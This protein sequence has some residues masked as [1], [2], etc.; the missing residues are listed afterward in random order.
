MAFLVVC[1]LF[2]LIPIICC[3]CCIPG[4]ILH[5][6]RER[7]VVYQVIQWQ[8]LIVSGS[9]RNINNFV[10]WTIKLWL[11]LYIP[12]ITVWL[13]WIAPMV[14]N[15]LKLIL[16][17]ILAEHPGSHG[18]RRPVSNADT[19]CIH[20]EWN[21]KSYIWSPF[22]HLLVALVKG[23]SRTTALNHI[24]AKDKIV[25][26]IIAIIRRLYQISDNYSSSLT[27]EK[28][29][30]CHHLPTRLLKLRVMRL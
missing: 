13:W 11:Y 12:Y 5:S 20:S 16:Y 25:T 4:C 10:L 14:A 2:V 8:L 19:T 9:W 18:T 17:Q 21:G 22:M 28:D 26:L 23:W 29:M 1:L 30:Q 7:R 6:C 27:I 3:C 24:R 15:V